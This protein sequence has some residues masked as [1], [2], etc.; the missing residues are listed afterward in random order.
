MTGSCPFCSHNGEYDSGYTGGDMAKEVG[1]II[2]KVLT[3]PGQ[4][5]QS[6]LSGAPVGHK[7]RCPKC[8]SMVIQCPH[9]SGINAYRTSEVEW[10]CVH[11]KKFY[12]I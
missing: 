7:G 8:K 5:I 9:C 10:S 4:L 6:G 11:C 12:Q 3:K 1:A 2:W